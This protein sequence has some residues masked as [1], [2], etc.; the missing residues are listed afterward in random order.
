MFVINLS[1]SLI[2]KSNFI[3]D[4]YIGE[5]PGTCKI[6][7]YL[8]LQASTGGLGRITH[9]DEGRPLSMFVEALLWATGGELPPRAHPSRRT[10][11][12]RRSWL[13]RRELTY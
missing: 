3:I 11:G 7:Y 12:Y 9:M 2:Y 13:Q 5:N 1:L 6:W 8:W 10:Q 4:M